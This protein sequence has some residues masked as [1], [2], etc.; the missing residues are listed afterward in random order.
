MFVEGMKARE[1]PWGSA[2]TPRTMTGSS[3]LAV[4]TRVRPAKGKVDR[5]NLKKELDCGAE[6]QFDTKHDGII[7]YKDRVWIPAVD[8]LRRLIFDESHKTRYSVH[9][10]ADKVFQD[11]REFYWWPGMKKDIAEY[12][13]QC[14]TCAKVKAEH[15]KQSGL[16]EQPEIP[17]WKW[18]QIA[19][20]FITKLPR[21]SSGHDTIWV[22]IDRLTKSAHF[23][24]MRETLTMDK[25]ARVYINEIMLHFIE[26]PL[27]IMDR[28]VKQL[29]RGRIP[30]VKVR[31]N[32][33][34]GPEFTWEL[35]DHM[36]LKYPQLFEEEALPDNNS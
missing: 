12:V 11:L 27:E 26:E 32:S 34:C 8:E 16:L 13:G 23:L 2:E 6:K 33:R 7:Y 15:Q 17:L 29:R 3:G 35:E 36:K 28:E 1:D 5:G 24:P 20:D 31:W 9:P 4:F 21:T 19:M 14:L 10:G 22:I 18:E 25:L 30:I